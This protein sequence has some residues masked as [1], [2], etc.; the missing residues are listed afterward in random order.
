M[1][2]G[3]KLIIAFSGCKAYNNNGDPV[4]FKV[5]G[6]VSGFHKF[7]YI[8]YDDRHL[9]SLLV[10]LLISVKIYYCVVSRASYIRGVDP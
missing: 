8:N 1:I 10:Y 3:Y 7:R 2:F 6:I 4:V 5:Y 9:T